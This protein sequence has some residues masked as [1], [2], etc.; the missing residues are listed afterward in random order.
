MDA[1]LSSS[2]DCGNVRGG[3][4]EHGEWEA[5]GGSQ[6]KVLRLARVRRLGI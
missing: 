3:I 6:V 1:R 5:T 4:H 2:G